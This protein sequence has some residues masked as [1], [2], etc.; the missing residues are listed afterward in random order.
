MDKALRYNTAKPRMDLLPWDAL[1]ALAE[2]FTVSCSKY[3]ARNWEKGL[4]WNEGCAASM[5]RHLAAWSQGEDI[6]P[7][8]GQY[9]DVAMLWNAIT[10][11]AHRLR[12]LGED[13]RPVFKASQE[14][15]QAD[16]E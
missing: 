11:V 7:E 1:V 3:P 10:L 4:K 14:A 6:D 13:D 8:N 16:T 9:H 15:V 12:N 2:H 5:A